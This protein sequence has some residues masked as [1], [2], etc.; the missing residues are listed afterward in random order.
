MM[1]NQQGQTHQ[2]MH[3]GNVPPQM[4]HGG[5]EVFDI[6]EVLSGAITH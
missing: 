2:N 6:H 3:T 5:H 1:E 4:N